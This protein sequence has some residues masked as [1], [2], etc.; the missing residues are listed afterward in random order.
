MKTQDRKLE[1]Q[2]VTRCHV[3]KVKGHAISQETAAIAENA[4]PNHEAKIIIAKQ[5]KIQAMRKI[6]NKEAS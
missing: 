1:V 5:G 2:R 6:Q 3:C 4:F